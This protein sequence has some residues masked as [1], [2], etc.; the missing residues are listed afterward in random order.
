VI[1]GDGDTWPAT[2]PV[3]TVTCT[4]DWVALRPDPVTGPAGRGALAV[5]ALLP[6]RTALV[7]ASASRRSEPQPLAANVDV[8]AVAVPLGAPVN[9]GRLE[10]MVTLAWESGARPLV[11]LT[12]ADQAG[13]P[14]APAVE[15]AE[16]EAASAAP[17]VAVVTTSA[18]DG[19]GLGQLAAELTGTS[20]LIG[21]SGAGK[22][23]LT[24]ALL[25]VDRQQTQAVRAADGK[26]RHTTVTRELLALPGGGVL[27]DTPGL[28]GVGLWAADDGLSQT[29]ADVE[30]LAADCRFAD[31]AHQAEP[32]CAVLAAVEAG[33]LPAR[34]LA[35]YRRLLR[36]NAYTAAR[37]DA[38]LR[39]E[40]TRLWKTR[41]RAS[42]QFYR[43][44]G[45]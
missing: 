5:V 42:R 25:G 31:C 23:T 4:G 43:D 14:G 12:K 13:G 41:T 9:L 20:V 36:E 7:R 37:D 22:S 27:I 40:Q 45:H 17:G 6:R 30:E 32:D 15:T 39:A 28:R 21:G 44:R 2:L 18:A 29:F 1:V 24:N 11:V 3:S 35:S 38:R 26:G 10:R 19:T 8:V 34:R 16:A 33:T